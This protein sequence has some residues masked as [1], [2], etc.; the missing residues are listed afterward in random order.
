MHFP[1]VRLRASL[2]T[3]IRT[4]HVSFL[5]IT[6]PVVSNYTIPTLP[7]VTFLQLHSH[8]TFAHLHLIPSLTPVISIFTATA[9]SG[10]LRVWITLLSPSF[11]SLV[12]SFMFAC[13]L[14]PAWPVF[15]P[16]MMV[17]LELSITCFQP[18]PVSWPVSSCLNCLHCKIKMNCYWTFKL[19][20]MSCAFESNP[21]I[22]CDTEMTMY[23]YSI[24]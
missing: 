10:S 14:I 3:L 1:P 2:I 20:C 8:L 11:S 21:A 18:P 12:T 13:F 22:N 4:H 19:C 15:C 24:P 16:F 6:C 5:F 9:P 17:C 23:M 7:A